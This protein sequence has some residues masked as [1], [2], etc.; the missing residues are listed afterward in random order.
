M[1]ESFKEF[2]ERARHPKDSLFANLFLNPLALRMAYCIKK[3]SLKITP[4]QVSL[5]RLFILS[6]IILLLLFLAPMFELRI[7]YLI[8]AI[9]FYFVLLTDW[10]DGAIA[11]GLNKTSKKGEFLD[12]IADRTSIIIFFVVIISV[13]LFTKNNFLVFGGVLL[14]VLKTFNLMVISKVFYYNLIPTKQMSTDE[15]YKDKNM[16]KIFGGEDAS[17][18]GIGGVVAILDKLNKYLKIKRWNPQIIQPELYSFI[19]ILPLLLIF[20]RLE[21]IAVYLLSI[22]VILYTIFFARRIKTLFKSYSFSSKP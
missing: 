11:R 14:F 22:L 4:N 13:G 1:A 10:L 8:I 6:S 2:C 5:T 20:F 7:L 16:F 12:A 17:K 15:R 21:T 9:L 19:I 18:M 3:Y